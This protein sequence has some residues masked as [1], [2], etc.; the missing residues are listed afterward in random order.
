MI[1]LKD[2]LENARSENRAVFLKNYIDVDVDWN[3]IV[4]EIDESLSDKEF[5]DLI[6]K[7]VWKQEN[8]LIVRDLFYMMLSNPFPTKIPQVN[9]V[10]HEFAKAF[11]DIDKYTLPRVCYFVNL[12][13]KNTNII[14]SG[15]ST[16]K[17][18][19]EY[20]AIF[21]Q[22]VSTTDWNIYTG[23]DSETPI[24]SETVSPGDIII[25]PKGVYHEVD[26]IGPR[27]GVQLTYP[28]NWRDFSF[29]TNM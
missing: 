21:I 27:A 24:Q 15:P 17:H 4:N 10:A 3:L 19:D 5:K 14:T 12:T 11:W 26:I 6:G 7:Y 29:K 22:L 9:K 25:I 16:P 13:S 18:C 28:D 1:N 8:A 23:K 20:D 2:E